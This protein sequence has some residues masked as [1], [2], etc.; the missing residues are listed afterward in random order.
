M[1]LKRACLSCAFICLQALRHHVTPSAPAVAAQR[2]HHVRETKKVRVRR[3]S[4]HMIQTHNVVL[5]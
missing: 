2:V 4:L 5:I 3:S 1:L